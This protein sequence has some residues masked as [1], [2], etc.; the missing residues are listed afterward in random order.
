LGKWCTSG[1]GAGEP[2]D[3]I[4]AHRTAPYRRL[5]EFLV[6]RNAL[7]GICLPGVREL[8]ARDHEI[9]SIHFGPSRPFE[10]RRVADY[11]SG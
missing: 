5:G 3:V 6:Q 7:L 8:A 2:A 1:A 11:E 10:T 4:V 9:W